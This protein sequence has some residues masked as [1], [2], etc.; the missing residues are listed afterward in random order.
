MDFQFLKDMY[1]WVWDQT[2]THL[3]AFIGGL[4]CAFFVLAKLSWFLPNGLLTWIRRKDAEQIAKFEQDRE[5]DSQKIAELTK[6][7]EDEA[8]KRQHEEDRATALNSL[9]SDISVGTIWRRN[10]R[11]V[12]PQF[13]SRI[14]GRPPIVALLN[15]K[16]GVGKTTLTANLGAAFWSQGRRVLLVDLDYQGS[17]TMLCLSGKQQQDLREGR[18]YVEKLLATDR[19]TCD[20][21]KSIRERVK[22]DDESWIIATD[23]ALEQCETK[24]MSSWIAKKTPDD[25]RY[26]LRTVLHS[27]EVQDAF[28]L[29]LLDCPPRLTTACINGLAASD[30]VLIPV[31]PDPVSADAAPRLVEHLRKLKSEYK[32]CPDISILGLVANKAQNKQGLSP[33]QLTV[34]NSLADECLARWGETV[35]QFET[36]IPQSVEFSSAAS[37]RTF[38][39]LGGLNAVFRDLVEE[40]NQRMPTSE[41]SRSSIVS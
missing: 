2:G 33:R 39:A 38:A 29:I 8:E 19:P 31:I 7:L 24:V 18:R 27:P 40:I 4:F 11:D 20:L 1:L 37:G 36:G 13:R 22:S 10:P 34:W 25:V 15:L 21:L 3:L 6:E 30:F 32:V 26:R 12:V 23:E 5:T 35:H 28:D 9:I 14:H 16:G 41:S 17:L